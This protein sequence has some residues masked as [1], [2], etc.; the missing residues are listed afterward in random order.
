MTF[1]N[2]LEEGTQHFINMIKILAYKEDA[3]VFEYVDYED[4][5]I[6]LEPLLFAYF[7]RDNKQDDFLKTMLLGYAK[8][9]LDNERLRINSDDNKNIYLP[10]LGW[11]QTPKANEQYDLLKSG[12]KI[13]LH[14][15]SGEQI[16]FSFNKPLLVNGTSIEILNRPIPLLDKCY[17]DF[18]NNRIDVEIEKSAKRNIDY[19][20]K[21]YGLIRDLVPDHYETISKIAPKCVIFNVE[22]HL[23]NSFAIPSAHGIGFYNAYQEDYDEVFFVDDIA[24]QTGHSIFEFLLY[25]K[26][27]F[28]KVPPNTIIDSIAYD[29]R[30]G[31]DQ[32]ELFIV[33]HALY[34]YYTTFICLDAC[35]TSD[36]FQGKQE[37][38]A[39]ARILFYLMKCKK[40]LK[41]FE[42]PK[43]KT[44]VAAN[45]LTESGFMIFNM[46]K[47]KW[48]EMFEKYY[49]V[50][51][52]F[53]MNNQP[54]NFTYS[55]FVKLN[56]LN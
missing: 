29:N 28:F 18:E 43:D 16:E 35:L 50:V 25:N 3:K 10:N 39:L 41:L 38:E 49:P 6:Y 53:N 13:I 20:T 42:N 40:D 1:K 15:I 23:R 11:I 54:Y 34:T 31:V 33:L 24:H 56:P 7:S 32:R 51:K 46:V 12:K 27:I 37:H 36:V 48:E 55:S 19:L 4:D 22:T 9:N 30:E 47:S 17:Y 45:T 8:D 52:E 2:I 5:N 14:S 44:N 26:E 21:A